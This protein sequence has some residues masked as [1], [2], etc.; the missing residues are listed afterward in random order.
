[1]FALAPV[2]AG[3][4]LIVWGGVVCTIDDVNAGEVALGS[5]VAIGEDLYLGSPVGAYE[6]ETDDRGD[7]INHSCDPNVW[8][9]DEVSQIARRDIATGDELTMDYAMIEADEQVTMRWECRCGSALCRGRVTGVDWQLIS[10]QGRY[11]GHFSPFINR[12]IEAQQIGIKIRRA[13]ESDA[14]AVAELHIRAWQWAYRGQ[15]PAWYLDR[16]SEDVE[17]RTQQWQRA[18][19]NRSEHR[20]WVAEARTRIVGFAHTAPPDPGPDA[21]PNPAEVGA[22]YLEADWAGKGVGRVL[23]AQAVEDLGL[24]GYDSAILWVLDSNARARRFYEIAGFKPDG[25]TKIEQRQG[26]ELREL[27]YRFDF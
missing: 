13:D 8:M 21:G 22:I 12:R 5:T 24:R 14:R 10:L 2:K 17:N 11:A 9:A 23:F 27:R 6:R 25:A 20:V 7:F 3:E 15:I 4:R 16:L 1:M 18:L 19:S 26:F